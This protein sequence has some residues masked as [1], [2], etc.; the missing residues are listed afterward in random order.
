MEEHDSQDFARPAVIISPWLQPA[1]T[2]ETLWLK[3]R[4]LSV[5]IG[6]RLGVAYEDLRLALNEV[7]TRFKIDSR[8]ISNLASIEMK[9]TEPGINLLAEKMAIPFLT[10][11]QEAI[12]PL[13]GTYDESA[14]V[15]EITGVGGVC[16]PA[17]RLASQL[18][19][20]LVPKQKI[21]PVAISVAME[22]SWWWD[23]GPA[24]AS[25]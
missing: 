21:G 22:R 3:P 6:C 20:T 13:A 7:L 24:T 16:E 5:G 9:A 18:G 12:I 11:S 8:C 17:A 4:N 14:W 2:A 10:F 23:W 1:E 19:I 15:K 25:I